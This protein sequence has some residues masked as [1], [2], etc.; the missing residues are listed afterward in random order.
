MFARLQQGLADVPSGVLRI[1][2][3][4][5]LPE[6]CCPAQHELLQSALHD[7]FSCKQVL[8]SDCTSGNLES[9]FDI[10]LVPSIRLF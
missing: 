2:A 4:G 6:C 5:H 7:P 8:C 1:W 10:S 3:H 9:D